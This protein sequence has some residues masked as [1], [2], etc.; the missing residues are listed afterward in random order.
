MA[1]APAGGDGGGA[2]RRGGADRLHGQPR[3]RRRQEDPGHQGRP[4]GHRPGPQGGQGAGR[5]RAEQR[6]GGRDQGG[7][8]PGQ[9]PARGGRRASSPSSSSRIARGSSPRAGGPGGVERVRGASTYASRRREASDPRRPGRPD[10]ARSARAGAP[11]ARSSARA[12]CGW[13]PT[14]SGAGV[15]SARGQT[16]AM[17]DQGFAGLDRSI[18]LG[19]LPPRE[20]DDHPQLRR[21]ERAGGRAPSSAC[22]PSTASAWPS[23]STT[24]RRTARL[25]LVGYRTMD[26]FAEA[27]AWIAAAGHPHREPLQL[28]PDPAL[29]RHRPRGPRGRRR[30]GRG[31]ALGQLGR[32]TTPSATGAARAAPGGTVIPIAPPPATPLPVQP[33][34]GAAPG[35]A[36][37][38]AV[39]RQDPAGG[40]DEVQRS[41]PAGA[42]ERGHHAA[43]PR[44]RA[45]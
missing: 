31:R 10:R 5:Q 41:A 37:S 1:A 6:Q 19:E 40:V 42:R 35:V 26:Q 15:S 16:V 34:A 24:S 3:R 4:R 22:R 9:G 8:R 28:V 32:A 20:R 11:R 23:S 38:V 45:P 18:A 43:R 30:G 12:P 29:R 13:A 14:R 27:A 25:V 17:L 2:R 21:G 36:A 33:R 44:T 7:G 39:E